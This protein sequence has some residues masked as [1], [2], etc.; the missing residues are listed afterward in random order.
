[1]K[2]IYRSLALGFMLTLFVA[3]GATTGYAQDVCAEV[4]PKLAL[5]KE[6]RDNYDKD[7]P[8][9]EI[10]IKAGKQYI[11][12]Y[13]ACAAD[14]DFVQ[15][16][17]DTLPVM[18]KGIAD[19]RAAGDKKKKDEERKALLLKFDAAAKAKNVPEVFTTGK[20]ILNRESEFDKVALDVAIALAAAGFEQSL[21][22][23]PVDTYS[24]DTVTYAKSAMQ[25]L[26][27]GKTSTGLGVWS[28]NL[29]NDKFQDKKS[30]ALGALNYIVG[31]VTYYRQGANSPEKKKEA[32]PYFYKATQFNSFTKNDPVVYQA[33]GAW[34]LDEALRIDKERA[35]IVKAAGDKDTPE[36]LAMI[37]LQKGYADRA[38][39]AYARTYKIAKA[40]KTQKIE[41]TNG[42]Y[43][44]LKDLYAFRYDNK[45]TGIDEFV[46]S[47]QSKPL[48]DPTTPITPVKE[49]A[50]ATTTPTATPT[51]DSTTP[52]T[53]KPATP[54]TNTTKPATAPTKPVSTTTTKPATEEGSATAATTA[55]TKAA[56]KKPAPKKKGTR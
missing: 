19:A 12:K 34:Y 15:Y 22:T 27:A 33:I 3:A 51:P 35:A 52:A 14:K 11:E 46:A 18:E 55:K 36:S 32:L 2:T 31:Y 8:K 38:I 21:A 43:T 16:L 40:D 47:V 4:E 54:A 44:K 50:P 53:T 25:K 30:Y 7:I 28:Y 49:E 6:F 39:D 37:G 48:P 41:Y 17:K 9:Q 45:T 29:K 5:D 20:E 24:A 10:A 23:P 1:M 42:L 56:A 26:E 13:G